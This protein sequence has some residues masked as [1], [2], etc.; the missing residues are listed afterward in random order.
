[1]KDLH[2][3]SLLI[4]IYGSLLTNK[5][6]EYIKMH[7][8]E[9]LSLSEIAKINNVTKNAIYD[10]I[11]ITLLEL[12]NYEEKLKIIFKMKQRYKLYD[13]IEDDEI[14]KKLFQIDKV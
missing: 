5:K 13:L 3:I 2:K 10:S 12:E 7:Y 6:L 8:F 11:K 1:M 4:D 14:K 9:D